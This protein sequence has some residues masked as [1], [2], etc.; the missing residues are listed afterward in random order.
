MCAHFVDEDRKVAVLITVIG[1]STYAILREICD[2]VL[3]NT[4]KYDKLCDIL[5]KQFAPQ[6]SVLPINARAE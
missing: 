1:A 5:S 3:P 2:P 4:V 6:V